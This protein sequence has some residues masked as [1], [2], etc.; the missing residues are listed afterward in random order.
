MKTIDEIYE[1]LLVALKEANYLVSDYDYTWED[2]FYMIVEKMDDDSQ[3]FRLTVRL[4]EETV[5]ATLDLV[6]VYVQ[7]RYYN[8]D[9]DYLPDDFEDEMKFEVDDPE[10]IKNLVDF[11]GNIGF[12]GVS[13][14]VNDLLN[15]IEELT[16]RYSVEAISFY[17]KNWT[18]VDTLLTNYIMH[19]GGADGSDTMWD[20]IGRVY[21]LEVVRHYYYINKTPRGNFPISNSAYEEG[22]CAVYRANNTLK[23]Q[24]FE[25]I[26]FCFPEIGVKSKTLMQ[27]ML[28]QKDL[29]GTLLREEQVGQYKWQ[30]ILIRMYLYLTNQGAVGLPMTLNFQNG[31]IVKPRFY[32]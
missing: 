20:I 5:H 14:L 10:L 27:Y 1:Q 13:D 7:E 3:A 9:D 19:S 2:S 30:L 17:Q 18:L 29:M 4:E 8:A 15:E 23:R 25:S 12:C 21:G 6:E 24:N 26:C 28:L 32:D 16:E 31:N 11:V 22:K